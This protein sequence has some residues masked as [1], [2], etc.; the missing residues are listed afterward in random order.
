[1]HGSQTLKSTRRYAAGIVALRPDQ[2]GHITGYSGIDEAQARH[3][4][5]VLDAHFPEPGTP[6]QAGEAGYMANAWVR[7]RHP[8]YDALRGIL[9]DIGELVQ[10]HAT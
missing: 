4:E 2:D 5:W 3:G 1:V 9:D 8:D 10:V 6:T 7:A